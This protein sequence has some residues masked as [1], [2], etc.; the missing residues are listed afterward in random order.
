MDREFSDV[1]APY[2][3]DA[4]WRRRVL[5]L[6]NHMLEKKQQDNYTLQS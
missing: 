3:Y 2:L 5:E 1:T 4:K 6:V